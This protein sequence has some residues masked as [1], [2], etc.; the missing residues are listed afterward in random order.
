V[1]R[2]RVELGLGAGWYDAE[3]TAYGFP[4]AP[5]AERMDVLAE[6]LEI[7]TRSWEG[8]PFDF[9]GAHYTVRG[10]DARPKPVQ[11]P[12]PPVIVGGLAGPRSIALATRWADEYNTVAAD[13]A[14]CAEIRARLD[15]A[16]TAAG[17]GTPLRLSLMTGCVVGT[18]DADVA[19]RVQ[20]IVDGAGTGQ[21]VAEWLAAAPTG[22]VV[23]TLD[24]AR[25]QLRALEAAGVERVMLQHQD[26]RDLAMVHLLGTLG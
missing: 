22:W 7:V 23:G 1:A 25:E 10:L 19:H 17:R 6:Q 18:D 11:Q 3:H 24:Q 13:A 26:H 5:M 14:R 8:G 2:A 4:F 9:D 21:T 20:A 16:G 15:A 12:H